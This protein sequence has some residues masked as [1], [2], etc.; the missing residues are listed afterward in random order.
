LILVSFWFCLWFDLDVDFDFWYWVWLMCIMWSNNIAHLIK[1]QFNL[2][3][4]ALN[5]WSKL[6]SPFYQSTSIFKQKSCIISSQPCNIWSTHNLKIYHKTFNTCS[7]NHLT[8]DRNNTEHLS[9]HT[10]DQPTM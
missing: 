9:N 2:F 7:N 3:K 4:Q 1:K 5:I 8:L 10:L 6:V